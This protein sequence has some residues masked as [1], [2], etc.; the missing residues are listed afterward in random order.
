MRLDRPAG[1]LLVFF[2]ASF[3]LL[4]SN[5]IFN[6]LNFIP[7]FFVASILI[8]SAGCVIN[9][10][11]DKDFDSRVNR[12]KGRVIASNKITL[13]EALVL[14]FFLFLVSLYFL[15]NLS[16]LSIKIGIVAFF[17]IITYPLM[18]RITYFPQIYLALTFN[19]GC[20]IAYAAI[21]NKINFHVFMIYIACCFWTFAY[22]T[23]YGFLD[24]DDDKK[25]GLKSTAIFF[26]NRGYKSWLT[27]SYLLFFV[28]FSINCY[29]NSYYLSSFSSLIIFLFVLAKII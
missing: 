14:L 2:P 3:G 29:L 13:R 27:I 28:I 23:V 18:K 21:N 16:T 22:D 11:I 8:R 17:M 20:L 15:V 10:I 4:F 1:Y 24:I 7:Y 19:L 26:E 6:N 9:D 12:T 25:I 5:N